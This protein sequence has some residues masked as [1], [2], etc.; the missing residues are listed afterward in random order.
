MAPPKLG[1]ILLI[2]DCSADIYAN[3]RVLRAAS[4]ALNIRECASADAGLEYL[5][6]PDCPPIDLILVDLNMPCKNGFDF[7]NEYQ[8]L[9]SE[10]YDST[11]VV[12]LSASLNPVDQLRAES[13]PA[14]DGFMEKPVDV[15]Q[16]LSFLSRYGDLPVGTKAAQQ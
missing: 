10:S 12:M 4:V 3:R 14:I 8:E 2:D 9:R 6:S 1:T 13:H 5:R 11:P 16:L 15:A 7:A